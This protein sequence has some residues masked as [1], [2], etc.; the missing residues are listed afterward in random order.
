LTTRTEPSAISTKVASSSLPGLH[1][2]WNQNETLPRAP[3]SGSGSSLASTGVAVANRSPCP[4]VERHRGAVRL[5][6]H[7][8]GRPAALRAQPGLAPRVAQAGGRQR[9]RTVRGGT[10]VGSMWL[11]AGT[12]A[13]AELRV[14]RAFGGAAGAALGFGT[15]RD[16]RADGMARAQRTRRRRGE[17]PERDE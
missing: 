9:M 8:D 10:V 17:S 13:R 15:I 12:R 3:P 5:E 11:P 2:G 1:C 4:H 16:A 7:P 6:Q 14:R